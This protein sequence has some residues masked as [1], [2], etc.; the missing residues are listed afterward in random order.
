MIGPGAMITGLD[1]TTGR[2][3]VPVALR[4]IATIVVGLALVAPMIVI[5]RPRRIGGI[6]VALA[7]MMIGGSGMVDVVIVLEAVVIPR[8]DMEKRAGRYCVG[9]RNRR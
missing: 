3:L 5:A 7:G 2:G 6:A 8:G 9:R 1:V 4:G